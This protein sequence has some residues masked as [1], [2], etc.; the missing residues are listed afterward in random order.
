MTDC[1]FGLA[2]GLCGENVG[3]F[4]A[5]NCTYGATNSVC[6]SANCVCDATVGV[7]EEIVGVF[8]TTAR[9]YDGPADKPEEAVGVFDDEFSKFGS[10]VLVLRH[11]FKVFESADVLFDRAF[12]EFGSAV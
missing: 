6:G 2:D 12:A 4:A 8:S 11:A 7:C 10:A 9:E 1:A 5:W 3:K